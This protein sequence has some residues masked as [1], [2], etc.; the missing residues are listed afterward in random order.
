MERKQNLPEISYPTSRVLVSCDV[1]SFL[2]KIKDKTEESAKKVGKEGA[3]LGKK[4]LKE[5]EKVAKKGAKATKKTVK[6]TK[7]KII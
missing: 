1:M 4:G 6:K 5:T 3:K 2:K 7:K